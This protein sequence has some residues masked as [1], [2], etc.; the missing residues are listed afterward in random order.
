MNVKG[1]IAW[2]LEKLS[3]TKKYSPLLE[4]TILLVCF[5]YSFLRILLPIC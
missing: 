5:G 1:N 3:T 4:G 2:V